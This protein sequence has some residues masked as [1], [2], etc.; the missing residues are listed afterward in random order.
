VCRYYFEM[1]HLIPNLKCHIERVSSLYL[2][3]GDSNEKIGFRGLNWTGSK[4]YPITVY[5]LAIDRL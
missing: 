2:Q 1:S 5:T 4:F 3:G